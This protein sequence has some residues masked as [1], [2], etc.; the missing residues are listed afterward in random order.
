[1]QIELGKSL[2]VSHVQQAKA[3]WEAKVADASSCVIDAS[4]LSR[5]DGA[6]L[7]LLLGLVL[8]CDDLQWQNVP[9]CLHTSAQ[10]AGMTTLLKLNT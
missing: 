5:I 4:Q 3:D 7:Q 8:S 2:D 1:M 10:H 9:D 6:G